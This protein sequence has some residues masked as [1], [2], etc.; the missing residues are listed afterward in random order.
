[1][2][3]LLGGLFLGIALL[4][5]M[6]LESRYSII[7]SLTVKVENER[8][9][10]LEYARGVHERFDVLEANL[11]HIFTAAQ[12]GTAASVVQPVP[13]KVLPFIVPPVKP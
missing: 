7:H 12:T 10:A 11:M 1:V 8:A 3:Y 9:A 5:G 13:A 6:W 2:L 4:F